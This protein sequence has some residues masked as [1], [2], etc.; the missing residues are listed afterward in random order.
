[1]E[2]EIGYCS[3]IFNDEYLK[4]SQSKIIKTNPTTKNYIIE[5]INT[6]VKI[7]S[8]KFV[9]AT[10][11]PFKAKDRFIND[12]LERCLLEVNI[13]NT[14]NY[15]LHI[16]NIFLAYE[17][18]KTEIVPINYDFRDS[19][20]DPEDEINIIYVLKNPKEYNSYVLIIS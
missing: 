19:I 17:K 6:V 2:I 7:Y 18:E 14:T 8:K 9:F 10:N 20:I 12:S 3:Q 13:T 4:Q 16:S 15:P 11:L 1:M 5:N